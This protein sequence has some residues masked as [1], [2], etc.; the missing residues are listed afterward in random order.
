MRKVSICYLALQN[1]KRRLFR[2]IVLASA[3]CLLVSLLIF[4]LSF[5]TSVNTCLERISDRLG[6]DLIVV[7]TG[8]RAIAEEFILESKRKTFY[9]DKR[10][11]EKIESLDEV[12]KTTYQ[13]YL[14]TVPG[15][16]CG[17]FDA[18]VVAIDQETDFVIAPWLREPVKLESG[19]VIVGYL[20]AMDVGADLLDT[21]LLF[22]KDFK[23]AGTLEKT[24]TGLDHSIFM[25][26]EDMEDIIKETEQAKPGQ[27]SVIFVKLKRG[28]DPDRVGRIIEGR[29]PEVDVIPRGDIGEKVQE[30]L[31]DVNKIFSITIFL[32]S[33][34]SL[35]LAWAI[36]SAI[37]NERKREIGI[38]GAIG[39]KRT[40]V[41]KL[42]LLEVI[43]IGGIGSIAGIITG[44]LLTA[45][46]T[47]EFIL[48]T[49]LSIVMDAITIIKI[50]I[51]CF[52]IGTLICVIGAL[53]PIIRISKL[54]PLVA[55]REE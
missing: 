22:E 37:V 33:I 1:V 3:I 48:L 42:F 19:E 54:E 23:V 45:Y 55:I 41:V 8:A 32:S 51:L 15:V 46:L 26:V 10:I 38:I 49:N 36:F 6:G 9:M 29:Y 7:P 47:K 52:L 4:A 14:K 12:E 53:F 50:S 30:T 43:L 20:S 17:I 28:Y 24:G 44:N 40:H 11:I 13:V 39:A 25:R 35:S 34:L 21:A 2:G 16:C 5:V 18:Q 31:V 27:V